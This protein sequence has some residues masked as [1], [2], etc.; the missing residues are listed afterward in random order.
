MIWLTR[1]G[2][3]WPSVYIQTGQ[4]MEPTVE[5]GEYFLSF[6][7]AD[8]IARG[9]LV[10]WRYQF[11]DREFHVLRR[12]AGLPG[13]TVGMEAGRIVVNGEPQDWNF[14][15]GSPRASYSDFAIE[16]ELY[17]WGPWIVP[18]DSLLLLSDRR[19]MLGFPDS[20]FRGFIPQDDILARVDISLTGRRL[21]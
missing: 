11:R 17:D 3:R 15:I 6:S 9:D 7:P 2:A 5:Q 16:G 14:V 1:G 19:D 4:S 20:R 10:I 8:P 21:R 18:D 12:V 13:D